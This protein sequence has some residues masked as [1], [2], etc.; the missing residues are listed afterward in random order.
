MPEITKETFRAIQ[1]WREECGAIVTLPDDADRHLCR[2]I[3]DEPAFNKTRA[4]EVAER[5]PDGWRVST[6]G[7]VDR[8]DFGLVLNDAPDGGGGPSVLVVYKASTLTAQ[9]IVDMA[10][11]LA[12]EDR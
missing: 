1:M 3:D 8:I 10:L 4:E 7:W 11:R 12:G 9:E 6:L 2:A 5:L